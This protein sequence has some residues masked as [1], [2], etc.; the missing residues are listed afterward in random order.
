MPPDDT[1]AGATA[2]GATLRFTVLGCGSSGGVPRIGPE[3]PN[4]GACDPGN[5]RNR[6]R[7]CAILVE[8]LAPGGR[9]AV[10]VDAGP[11]IREQLIDAGAGWLDAVVFTHD[12]ADHCHGIDDLR[13]VFFNRRKRL[14]AYMDPPTEATLMRR[15]G[16]VFET[17]EGSEYPPILDRL[18]LDGPFEIEGPGG[19]IPFRPFEVPHGPTR[20]LGF[21]I[22]PLA[23]APD[24]SA[25]TGDAWEAVAGA[26]LWL[27]DALRYTPHVSH[28]NVETALAWIQ[29]SGIPRAYLTN[30]HV[31]LD[32]AA[33]DAATPAHVHPAFDG[34]T[35]DFAA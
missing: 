19:A 31:D 33:L 13:M 17:P 14:P 22:G 7:R 26:E 2:P 10:L 15:F 1:G 20:A 35:L 12:H 29:Q 4:W 28:A 18:P 6:R 24:I 8:R 23:Y 9:T 3:G 21:R 34:L 11:D 30:L 25:M 27:L 32:Y 16:Y 5:P